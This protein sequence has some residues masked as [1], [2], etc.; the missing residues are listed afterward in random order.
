ML[1]VSMAL[2][3]FEGIEHHLRGAQHMLESPVGPRP[4]NSPTSLMGWDRLCSLGSSGSR[5]CL[6]A[7]ILVVAGM[8]AWGQVHSWL[9]DVHG[10]QRDALSRIHPTSNSYVGMG[11]DSLWRCPPLC[12]DHRA[13]AGERDPPHCP[14][15]I[16]GTDICSCWG[17]P[18]PCP[19]KGWLR[20]HGHP[21]PSLLSHRERKVETGGTC[22][23]KT[24]KPI[25]DGTVTSKATHY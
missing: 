3:P 9:P 1:A 17:P 15:L 6:W 16:L 4:C 2:S 8:Q 23:M 24:S 14:M 19:T 18:H 11:G 12:T 10:E 5:A 13:V 21:A 22:F 7:G 20:Q 25:H